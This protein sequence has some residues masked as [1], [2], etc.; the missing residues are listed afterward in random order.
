MTR[1]IAHTS[2]TVSPD[3]V[4]SL[5]ALDYLGAGTFL[6]AALAVSPAPNDPILWLERPFHPFCGGSFDAL[7]LSSLKSAASAYAAWYLGAGVRAKDP[8]AV[9][10]DD[11]IEYLVHYVALTSLGA[12]PVLTNGNL[13]PEV[14][15][16]YFRR[17][18]AVGLF[19][20]TAHQT[21]LR[22]YLRSTDPFRF[23]VVDADLRGLSLPPLPP[24]YP[25]R[26]APGDPIMIAHS[27][28]TTGVPK[29]VVLQ[30]G[31]FFH[32]VRYRLRIS[33]TGAP[34]RILSALPHSHNCAMAYIMLALL[35]G[36]HVFVA[37]D[38]TGANVAERLAS[39]RPSMVVAF[40]QTYVELTE[41]NLDKRDFSSVRF[42][43][44]GGD[45]AHEAHIRRLT[46]FGSHSQGGELVPGSLFIDGM[47]SSE[48]GFSLF[49]NAH[50]AG[51][52]VYDRCVG[53]PIEWAEAA[54]FDE[55]GSKVEPGVIGRLAV[56]APSVTSGYWN[57][58]AL[59]FRSQIDGYWLTGDLAY[60]DTEGR[61]FHVDRTPDTVKTAAGTIYSLRTE[62]FLLATFDAF[63][64]CSVVGAPLPGGTE[65][66]IL[67]ARLR[68]DPFGSEAALLAQA[69]AA[70]E[71]KGWPKLAAA[72]IVTSADIPLGTTGKV[73]KRTLRE[74]LRGFFAEAKAAPA[75]VQGKAVT[76]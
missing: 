22:A 71:A 60:R 70:L 6:E 11:G 12:I 68:R 40:P 69:N 62:E 73:L 18:G 30:H 46:A 7:S 34:E 13:P 21:A 48:M 25:F 20:D 65:G 64:D 49:R 59:T 76:W 35:A 56:R 32:G 33:S 50:G 37:S 28:G 24:T 53:K 4:A 75:V 54:V 43:F 51:P 63:A 9:Y 19:V 44:N 58:S 66:G 55:A 31:P 8:V 39:F 67:L 3:G 29:A 1:P 5:L 47:G 15:A 2:T 17:V 38:H 36:N 41:V 45:A 57:D 27:S 14:A 16:E 72:R 52:S 61:F 74:R 10:L 23:V 42:W 26:H